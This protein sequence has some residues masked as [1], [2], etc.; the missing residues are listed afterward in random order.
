LN[1]GLFSLKSSAF[2]AEP[3]GRQLPQGRSHKGSLQR[4]QEAEKQ[5][6]ASAPWKTGQDFGKTLIIETL[7]LFIYH[8]FN[9]NGYMCIVYCI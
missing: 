8:S 4:P 6:L 7:V 3:K 2:T 9:A 1:L 5:K